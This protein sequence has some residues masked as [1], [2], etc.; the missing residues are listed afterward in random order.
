MKQSAGILAYRRKAA[1]VEVLLLH[2]AGPYWA[3]KDFWH[4]PQGELDE[5]EDSLAAAHREFL[6]EVGVPVPDGELYDLGV[7]KRPGKEYDMWALEA[8]VDLSKFSDTLTTNVFTMEWPPKSGQQQTYPEND[9]AEWFPL[10]VAHRKVF[11]YMQVFI[12]R[13][14]DHLGVEVG[15]APES[16]QQSLL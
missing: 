8:D 6:E 13:L 9:R 16:G 7:A 12:E 4:F 2:P 11:G 1:E 15:E 14:A 10:A 5:G 3:H